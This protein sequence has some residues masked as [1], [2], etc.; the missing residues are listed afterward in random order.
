MIKVNWDKVSSAFG[1]PNATYK[2]PPSRE[3]LE[4]RLLVRSMVAGVTERLNGMIVGP[5]GI[6]KTAFAMSFLKAVEVDGVPVHPVYL[7]AVLTSS[8]TL[9]VPFPFLDPET[10][11][12]YLRALLDERIGQASFRSDGRPIVLVID[13]VGQADREL[14]SMIMEIL[15]ERSVGNDK[16]NI[17]ASFLLDNPHDDSRYGRL[18]AGDFASADRYF[19]VPITAA[20]SPWQ[21]AVA[22]RYPDRDLSKV[23]EV[24]NGFNLDAKSRDFVSPRTVDQGI[25]YA[26]ERGLPPELGLPWM[27]GERVKL[28]SIHGEDVTDA[29]LDAIAKAFGAPASSRF[30]DPVG[31]AVDRVVK[32][33]VSVYIEGSPGVGKSSRVRDELA[34]RHP[35]IEVITLSLPNLSAEDLVVVFP[36]KDAE[37]GW[38]GNLETMSFDFFMKSNSRKVIIADEFSR[39]W[40]TQVANIFNEIVQN[41]SVNGVPIPGLLGV[42][43]INNPPTFMGE[44]LDVRSLTLPQAS[45]FALSFSVTAEDTGAFEWL[46]GEY[47][48]TISP[49]IEWW[50][51]ALNNDQ[52]QAITAR[53][54]ERMY[55]LWRQGMPLKYGLPTIDGD[56]VDCPLGDLKV[57]LANQPLARLSV[58]ARDID[59]FVSKMAATDEHGA[60]AYPATHLA[61]YKAFTYAELSQLKAH[62][63]V[64]VRIFRVINPEYRFKLLTVD[65]PEV[66]NFWHGVLADALPAA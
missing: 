40:D 19:T 36:K 13:E 8:D 59:G 41:K 7:N 10:G 39:S 23:F 46:L 17:I 6:G 5:A 1:G 24:H 4:E 31:V 42:I 30:D 18:S 44:K 45:R 37:G 21:W 54:L 12:Q 28:T 32:D 63:Q 20:D 16:L 66:Q 35:D 9:R 65:K 14:Y 26:L 11:R 50:K 55:R 27:D 43:A 62:R 38:D 48:E 56:P 22:A 3:K 47:G 61:A 49:F 15:S 33:G 53:T 29:Y 2:K 52:R 60:P 58:L 34:R 51:E 64:C 57:L 25:L